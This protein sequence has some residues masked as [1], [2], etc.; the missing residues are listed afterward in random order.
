MPFAEILLPPPARAF[1]RS[2]RPQQAIDL[3]LGRVEG[4]FEEHPDDVGARHFEACRLEVLG[5][6]LHAIDETARKAK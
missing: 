6:P 5:T 4:M 1:F 2:R 3:A